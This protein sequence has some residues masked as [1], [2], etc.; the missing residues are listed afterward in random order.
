MQSIFLLCF[1]E[2]IGFRCGLKWVDL[3]NNTIKVQG[4]FPALMFTIVFAYK[5][6]FY[7]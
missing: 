5:I 7:V 6:E 1:L 3:S 4:L 2:K